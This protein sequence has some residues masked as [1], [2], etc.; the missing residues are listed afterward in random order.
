[1]IA[2]TSLLQPVLS[3]SCDDCK[4]RKV[5]CI[6]DHGKSSC[7]NCLRREVRCHFSNTKRKLRQRRSTSTHSPIH[8]S[9]EQ[10]NDYPT[11][12]LHTSP[13]P[14]YSYGAPRKLYMERILEDRHVEA[15]P[16]NEDCIFKAHEKYVASSSLAF[17]SESR[18]R[19]VSELLGHTKLRDLIETM[20]TVING[21]MNRSGRPSGS[22]IKFKEPSSAVQIP[23]E[24]AASYIRAYFEQVHPLY[25][26]LDRQSFEAKVCNPQLPQ[27][28]ST[29]APFSALYHTVLALGCQYQ[30]GGTFDP[31]QGKAWKLFQISLGLFPDVLVPRESLINVQAV[32]AMAIF[33]LN[34]SCLQIGQMMVSE[35]ARMAQSLGFGRATSSSDNAEY[36]RT[37]W[38]IYTIEK[39]DSF[40]SGRN[41]VLI[42]YDIGAPIPVAP[43]AMFG[44]FDW[45]LSSA[46]FSRLLSKAFE[47]LFSVTARM[48]SVEAYYAAI[49]MAGDD[50]ERWRNSIPEQFRP[51]LPFRA[52]HFANS[53]TLQVALRIHYYYYSGAIALSRLTLNV[54]AANPGSRQS[55][56]KKALM[57]AARV[58]IELTRY[59]DAEAYTPIWILGVM[60]LSALFILFD[61]VVHNPNHRETRSNLALLDVAAGYFSRLEYATGGSLPSSLLSDFAHIAR[62]FVRDVQSRNSNGGQGTTTRT[63]DRP[64]QMNS[65]D[66]ANNP[67]TFIP[68][69]YDTPSQGPVSDTSPITDYLFYPIAFPQVS[70]VD[71]NLPAPAGFDI[72]NLFDTVIPDFSTPLDQNYD[73]GSGPS[74]HGSMS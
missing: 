74:M 65:I 63:P 48:N 20:I 49:D 52:Q 34:L 21:R 15:L 40:Y 32:T 39:M 51:G 3:K 38:V 70:A 2:A 14:S 44:D 73:I 67:S 5:R 43:E 54:G 61:F 1:M 53:C 41:S 55:Q 46:R 58:I 42:D 17:F 64:V 72:M 8:W 9:A 57:N 69:P 62:Q 29:S 47:M 27:L 30:E 31:G 12:S 22:I 28:L 66:S 13:T 26:F 60:P 25:P 45:F 24:S 68:Q 7:T 56:S 11:Q 18:I 23:P 4:A 33:A 16:R 50:L 36:H 37:F 6:R 59:I 35:A 71:D 19:S 10:D